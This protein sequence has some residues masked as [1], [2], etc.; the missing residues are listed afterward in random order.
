[1]RWQCSYYDSK[2]IRCEN[3]ALHRVHFS[4]ADPFD[5]SD[6]C[7]EHFEEYKHFCWTEDLQ[8]KNGD[9]IVQ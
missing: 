8:L 6:V 1:M 5:F 4:S 2:G 3:E 7:D 9:T